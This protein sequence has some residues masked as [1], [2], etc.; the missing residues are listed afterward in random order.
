M[1]EYL[2]KAQKNE[3]I[4][5]YICLWNSD[6]IFVNMNIFGTKY[7]NVQIFAITRHLWASGVS[8]VSDPRILDAEH[9]Q[10]LVKWIILIVKMITYLFEETNKLF[11]TC[12]GWTLYINSIIANR[13]FTA[14][15][16]MNVLYCWNFYCQNNLSL[17][18]SKK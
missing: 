8:G 18:C 2:N 5:E 14:E 3:W 15:P 12:C 13:I 9:P 7:L 17:V 16:T 1:N 11:I 10:I 6:R 4:S